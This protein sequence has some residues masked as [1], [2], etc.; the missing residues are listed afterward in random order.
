VNLIREKAGINI[1]SQQTVKRAE[2]V[3]VTSGSG[4]KRQPDGSMLT[5]FASY[6]FDAEKRAE[7]DAINQPDKYGTPIAKRKHLLEVAKFGEQRSVTGFQHALIHKLAKISRSFKT[8]EELMRGMK[9]LRIDRNV[10]GIMADPSM[11]DAVIKHA[12]G[13]TEDVFGPREPAKQITR[14]VDAQTGEMVEQA[15]AAEEGQLGMFPEAEPEEKPE[16][17]AI[18]KLK[19]VLRT[20]LE[21]IPADLV[22]KQGNV[23]ELIGKSLAKPDATEIEINAWLDRC[24]Q[25]FQNV[26]ARNGGAA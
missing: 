7:L 14:T 25:Y 9:V 13:A 23:R 15:P 17:S 6:E 18:D 19:A 22:I 21:K 2:Y 11:R 24:A 20:Q 5:D 4:E 3:W 8:P 1:L 10:N 16:P 26:Q 12:L